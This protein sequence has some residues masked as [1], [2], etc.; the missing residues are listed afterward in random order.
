MPSVNIAMERSLQPSVADRFIALLSASL[1]PV[2]GRRD[3]VADAQNQISDVKT[4]FSSWD[5]CMNAVY[6]KSVSPIPSYF[7][8]PPVPDR[9]SDSPQMARN[10]NHR[11]RRP[12]PLLHRLVHLTLPLLRPLLLL[13]VLPMP[14]MLRQLLRMLR[15]AQGQEAQVPRRALCAPAPRRI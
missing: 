6:C 12:I 7:P 2:V 1:E 8:F 9:V 4:A 10:S 13:R 15:P 11:C 3:V 5:N 14:E